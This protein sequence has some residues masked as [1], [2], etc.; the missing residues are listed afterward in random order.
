M[1]KCEKCGTTSVTP[2]KC[3]TCGTDMMEMTVVP[4]QA[5]DVKPADNTGTPTTPPSPIP[6]VTPAA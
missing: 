1:Y 5:G 6:P 2:A 4:G 3:P